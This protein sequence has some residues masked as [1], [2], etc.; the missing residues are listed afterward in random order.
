M[1]MASIDLIMQATQSRSQ[2]LGDAVVKLNVSDSIQL[3]PGNGALGLAD[4]LYK[5]TRTLAA[6]ASEN[7]DLSGSLLDAFGAVIAPA[8][9][10]LIYVKAAAGNTNNVVIGNVTHAFPGPLGANGTYTVTPGDYYLATSR[11]GWPVVNST[12]DLLKIANSGSGTA[13]TYD[14]VVIGRSVAG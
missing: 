9:I 10:V 1:V 6:S 14:I 3:T 5:D 11:A 13:V 7:L 4:V 12:G 8:E 2:D